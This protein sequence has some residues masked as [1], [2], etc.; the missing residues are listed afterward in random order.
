V[1]VVLPSGALSLPISRS[2]GI[3]TVDGVHA[4]AL[5]Q[6]GTVNSAANPAQAGSIVSIF[7]TGAAW[8]GPGGGMTFAQ[9]N[10]FQVTDQAGARLS[11]LYAGPAPGLS[12]GVFQINVQLAAK[13]Y[14]PLVLRSDTSSGEMLA[15]NPVQLYIQ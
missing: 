11:L 10:G 4:A 5:N 15:S 12:D 1:D 8:P 14:V 6:D 9:S 3:F 13:T 7:G 2:I